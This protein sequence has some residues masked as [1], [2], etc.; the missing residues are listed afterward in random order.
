[1][2]YPQPPGEEDALQAD[3]SIEAGVR[4]G[5]IARATTDEAW[6]VALAR[7]PE[8]RKGQLTHKLAMKVSDSVWH[9]KLSERGPEPGGE[10]HPYWLGP[11]QNYETFCPYLVGSYAR[12]AQEVAGY[13]DS[14][15]RTFILDIPPDEEELHHTGV[16]FREAVAERSR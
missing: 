13:I 3:D 16:V 11:F 1:V 10:T 2:K 7:F 14:G 9:R 15:F 5:V 8:D 4:V 6:D 12:V